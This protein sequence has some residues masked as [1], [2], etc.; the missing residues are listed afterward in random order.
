M[1]MANVR[2]LSLHQKA[3]AGLALVVLPVIVMA[4]LSWS[5]VQQLLAAQDQ[6][7]HLTDIQVQA[8]ELISLAVDVQYGFRG[9]VITRN[10]KYLNPLHDAEDRLDQAFY[11]LK[12]MVSDDR[13]QLQMVIAIEVRVRAFLTK[14]KRLVDAVRSGE[15]KLVR[16]HFDSG[17]GE[18]TLS[19]IRAD[20]HAFETIEHDRLVDRQARA[21]RLTTLTRYGL[22]GVVG[23]T[24]LLWWIGGRL[25]TRTITG[26]IGVLTASA[27]AFDVKGARGPIPISS[28]DELGRLARTMEEMQ[29]RVASHVHQAEA[30]QAIGKEVNTI[31]PGGLEGVLKRIAELAA[32]VLNVDLCLVLLWEET[33]GCWKVGAASGHWH[34]LL[35]RSVMVKEETPISFTA[36]TTGMPQVV[37]DLQARSE[38]VLQIRDRLGG[39]SLLAVP[40]LGP[41]G[42][43]GVLVIAPTGEKRAFTEWDVSLGR[44]FAD[45]AAIAILNVRLY[46]SVQQRG[47]G[48]KSR[49]EQLERYSA[50]M[51]HDLKGP[52]RRMA[53]LASLLQI[54]YKDRL[55]ERAER[56]LAWI[57][58]NGLQL[59][60]RIEEVLRLARIG[61]IQ[62]AIEVVDPAEVVRDIL[63]GCEEHLDRI[64]A[65]VC[66][67][68]PFPRL[69]C[70]RVHLFQVL[71]NLV[72]NALKFSMKGRPLDLEIGVQ[73]MGP[74]V[75]LF[76][77]DNGIGI[78]L[79]DRERIFEPFERLG[80][81]D[82]PG[83]GIGLAIVK[84]IVEL[85]HGRVW[86]E[87]E[88]GQGATVFFTLPLYGELPVSETIR[89]RM[90]S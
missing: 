25:L 78:A 87:S 42:A 9:F 53:E 38:V 40:F 44:Q 22:A 35:C 74:E 15:M 8:D 89:E 20:Y 49:L 14:K 39:K 54:D 65:S 59:M 52:A 34:D 36:L 61:T 69:A 64:K 80:Q 12:Q 86:I 41:Q 60:A 2:R 17:E 73:R 56:Y 11:K 66:V 18:A 5:T 47:E 23:S 28:M 43:F 1:S 51:A 13:E 55:D 84:K 6:A 30:V 67:T 90:K 68:E 77:R 82:V 79:P 88:P 76:V 4:S 46:E 10:E 21:A 3:M 50:D 57:R 71:D 70:N 24:L 26:P 75:A 72:R 63:K 62:E 27:Q 31:G 83:T 19:R 45:W 85:Y 81:K 32:G 48:L 29:E 7:N 37:E 16:E 58:E 33:I